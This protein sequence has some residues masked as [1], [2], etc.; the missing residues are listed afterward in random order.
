MPGYYEWQNVSEDKKV[1]NS[2]KPVYFFHCPQI[3]GVKIEDNSTWRENPFPRLM[4]IAGVFDI[5]KDER[6]N[7]I[8]SF[9]TITFASD[10]ELK[11]IH[12]RTPAVLESEEQIEKWINYE[13][14]GTDV[15][16]T[17]IKHPKNLSYHQVTN[18]VNDGRNNSEKCNKPMFP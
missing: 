9:S 5:W 7:S 4:Y 11:W 10:S 1:L 16:M 2:V 15:A 12:D 3:D 8:Y 18:Y 13:D 14:Y 17:M 6:K